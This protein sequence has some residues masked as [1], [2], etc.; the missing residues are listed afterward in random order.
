MAYPDLPWRLRGKGP[1]YG[2]LFLARV[3][4][5]RRYI[6]PQLKI[7]RVLPGRTLGFY[8]LCRFG[9]GSEIEYNE[10][11]LFPALVRYGSKIGFWGE[12]MYVDNPDAKV[13]IYERSGVPKTLADFEF[14]ASLHRVTVLRDGRALASVRYEPRPRIATKKTKV[15]KFGRGF[16]ATPEKIFYMAGRF[17]GRVQL[18]RTRLV[19]P[20]GSPH[21]LKY[22]GRT[23]LGFSLDAFKAVLFETRGEFPLG[24]PSRHL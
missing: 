6:P 9:P 10:L 19:I 12:V 4:N 7:V 3:K 23:F 5:L 24:K 8:Y 21:D 14:G 1:L 22:I 11:V 2:G 17:S 20:S 18:R 16:G 15:L 13:G